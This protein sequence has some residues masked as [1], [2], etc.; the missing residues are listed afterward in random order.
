MKF[1]LIFP[2]AEVNF[3]LFDNSASSLGIPD[4][5]SLGSFSQ[6]SN[7]DEEIFTLINKGYR[8]DDLYFRVK[9]FDYMEDDQSWRPS[10]SYFLFSKFKDNF[11]ISDKSD[12][13][14]VLQ[15][16]KFI[17]LKFKEINKEDYELYKNNGFIVHEDQIELYNNKFM[18]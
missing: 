16:N 9:V 15:Y 18:N 4:T 7:S 3:R 10:S 17:G 1:Y 12:L 13:N 14:N 11:K 5:I 6:F 8:Q 2:R